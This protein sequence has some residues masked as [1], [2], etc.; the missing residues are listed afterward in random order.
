LTDV[1]TRRR[2]REVRRADLVSPCVDLVEIHVCAARLQSPPRA[3]LAIGPRARLRLSVLRRICVVD[4]TCI[5]SAA[6]PKKAAGASK[7]VGPMTAES[8]G[9]PVGDLTERVAQE[10][11]HR[12]LVNALGPDRV[13]SHASFESKPFEMDLAH[14]LPQRVRVYM[15]NAT[16]PPGG[17]PLGEHKVQ[18]IVPG[19]GRGDRGTFNSGDGRIVLLIGY[20]AEE[21]VFIVWDAGLYSDFA[22]SRN[23][24]VKAE[25]IIQASAGKIATQERQLRPVTGAPTIETVLAAKPRRL[26]EAITRRM[27]LTR[28]RLLRE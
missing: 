5:A 7:Q 10:E 26:A 11:L 2:C 20:A 17:R 15:Y 22:W 18:L 23:V 12:R 1:N 13:R 8:D 21:D 27:E 25:T 6:V 14:P 9:R 16:R 24:Q 3:P 19:Q 4:T 28:E